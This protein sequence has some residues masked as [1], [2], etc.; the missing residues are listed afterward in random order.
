MN[1]QATARATKEAAADAAAEQLAIWA[2]KAASTAAVQ[3]LIVLGWTPAEY[4]D[5]ARDRLAGFIMDACREAHEQAAEDYCEALRVFRDDE[6]AK[7]TFRAAYALAGIAAA[8]AFHAAE[9]RTID[10]AER[11]PLERDRRWDPA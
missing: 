8:N 3:R 11:R 10:Q 2:E 1:A 4:T 9:R 6:I 7:Q 5:A